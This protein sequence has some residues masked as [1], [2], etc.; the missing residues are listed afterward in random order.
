VGRRGNVAP[1]AGF[2][3]DGRGIVL[4]GR[5]GGRVFDRLDARP[6][7][8][9]GLGAAPVSR[10]VPAPFA[11]RGAF[12]AVV[13]KDSQPR[14]YDLRDGSRATLSGARVPVDAMAF[15]PG[16][17]VLATAGPD[18]V[19]LWDRASGELLAT[20]ASGAFRSVAFSPDGHWVLAGGPGKGAQVLPCRP[21][22]DE[23]AVQRAAGALLDENLLVTE[24]L[25][26]PPEDAPFSEPSHDE[27][28]P[29]VAAG[30][31]GGGSSGGGGGGGGAG[32][33]GGGGGGFGAGLPAAPSTP[34][35]APTPQPAPVLPP[36]PPAPQPG[37]AEATDA[38]EG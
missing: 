34:A 22:G 16:G 21:C 4:V 37:A 32:G 6:R 15:S 19:R 12:V 27:S 26:E 2:T 20:L 7:R 29:T 18:G 30:G 25:P 38:A 3:G 11:A 1:Y 17:E 14:V 10:R 28:E 9:A 23:A 35:P 36:R 33:G 5:A 31:S 24:P 8:L 13:A